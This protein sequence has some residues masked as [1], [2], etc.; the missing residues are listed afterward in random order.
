MLRLDS[1]TG[2][3]AG[4]QLTGQAA[5]MANGTPHLSAQ[6]ALA[7]LPL[8][9]PLLDAPV[10]VSAGRLDGAARLDAFGYSPAALL[11]TLSGTVQATVQGG[12]LTGLDLAGIGPRWRSRMRARCRRRCRPS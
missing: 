5:L 10:D 7:N 1:F 9:G 6:A 4:G 3:V 12:T 11:A 2:S 8:A